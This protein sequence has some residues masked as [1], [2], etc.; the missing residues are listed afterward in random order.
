LSGSIV[1]YGK[2]GVACELDKIHGV[3]ENTDLTTVANGLNG[4]ETYTV[5]FKN[6]DGTTLQEETLS[7]GAMPSFKGKTPVKA[8]DVVFEYVFAGWDKAIS[9]VTG[10]VVYT[11]TYTAVE[12]EGVNTH[13]ATANNGGI[14]LNNSNIGD[15]AHYSGSNNL[16]SPA[17]IGTV[18]QSY[19]IYQIQ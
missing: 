5:T 10:E 13:N 6:A 9:L 8:E 1:L 15:S 19:L 18:N 7:Y 4:G 3:F 12:K 17:V 2:F 11:A 16:S 14:V